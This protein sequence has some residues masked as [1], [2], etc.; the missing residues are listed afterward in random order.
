MDYPALFVQGIAGM[1]LAPWSCWGPGQ[2]STGGWLQPVPPFPWV[3]EGICSGSPSQAVLQQCRGFSPSYPQ[4]FLLFLG[5]ARGS[6][7]Q[8][9]PCPLPSLNPF[10]RNSSLDQSEI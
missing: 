8:Q 5:E 10:S 4:T 9:H 6:D 3:C 1:P 2:F 7:L